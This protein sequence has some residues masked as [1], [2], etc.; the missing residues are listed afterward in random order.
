MAF[1]LSYATKAE[2]PAGL[3][4]EFIEKDGKW[5]ADTD[6]STHP[7]FIAVR[8]KKDELLNE[9]KAAKKERDEARTHLDT[10]K[11]TLG[12]TDLAELPNAL[13]GKQSAAKEDVEKLLAERTTAMK[14]E[15]EGKIKDLETGRAQDQA[16]LQTVLIDNTITAEATKAGVL[17]TAIPDVLGRGRAL[18][19]LVDGKPV[20]MEGDKVLYGK[21]GLNPMPVSEW[22]G[23]LTTEAPHLFNPSQGGNSNPGAGGRPPVAGSVRSRA[24]LKT[25]ADKSK[26]ITEHGADA[27]KA[28]PATLS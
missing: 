28:L 3:V 7:S 6:V 20:P 10:V 13:K 17:P 26:F 5:I 16:H 8:D 19:K 1:N 14:T 22:F 15:Y 12:I 2:I 27:Y 24:E 11:S 25:D 9:T 18:Y 23:R 21:D 4:G